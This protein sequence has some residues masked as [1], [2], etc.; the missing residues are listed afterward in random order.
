MRSLAQ[1]ESHAQ[2]DFHQRNVAL[3]MQKME[4]WS[5]KPVVFMSI[6]E[7]NSNALPWREAGAI[8]ELIPLDE[9]G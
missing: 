6:Y 7:H 9:E 5:E 1:Y 8:I 4:V 2:T 3:H